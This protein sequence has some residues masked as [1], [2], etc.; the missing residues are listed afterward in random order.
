M[1]N[2]IKLLINGKEIPMNPFVIK[3]IK[4]VNLAIINNLREMPDKVKKIT[5]ILD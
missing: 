2:E 3:I 5:I 1:S 4:D